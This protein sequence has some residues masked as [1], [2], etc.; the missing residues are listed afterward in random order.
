MIFMVETNG[1]AYTGRL[2]ITYTMNGMRHRSIWNSDVNKK[3]I[4]EGLI[5]RGAANIV[6]FN[7]RAH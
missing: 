6:F 2:I 1:N 3:A 5:K 7:E 4:Q